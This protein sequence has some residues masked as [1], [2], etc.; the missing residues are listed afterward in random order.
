ML[1]SYING[2]LTTIEINDWAE[3][4]ISWEIGKGQEDLLVDRIVGEFAMCEDYINEY[5]TTPVLKRF[6]SMLKTK[7]NDNAESVLQLLSYEDRR[8][9]I[10]LLLSEYKNGRTENLKKFLQENFQADIDD[11]IFKDIFK[12]ASADKN[13]NF[14]LLDKLYE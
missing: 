10:A 9:A 7:R 4:Q 1:E 6:I 14:K 12:N 3:N 13:E 5:L 8:N 11:F 2:H